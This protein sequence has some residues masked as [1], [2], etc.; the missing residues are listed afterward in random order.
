M[1]QTKRN[2]EIDVLRFIFIV[3]IILRHI[4]NGSLLNIHINNQLGVDI[5]VDFFFIVT[6]YLLSNHYYN[7]GKYIEKD[8]YPDHIWKY[9]FRKAS[10]IYIYI[11]YLM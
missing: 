5:G 8:N 3:L 9:V 7:I 4:M 2:G 10:Y 1:K 6:G 11:Y